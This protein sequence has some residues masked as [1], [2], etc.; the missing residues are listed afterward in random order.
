MPA[1]KEQLIDAFS[2]Q[3]DAASQYAGTDAWEIGEVKAKT[4]LAQIEYR[5]PTDATKP[6]SRFFTDIEEVERLTGPDGKVD[7]AALSERL[8]VQAYGGEYNASVSVYEVTNDITVPSSTISDNP[9][10]G[11]GGA[12]QY[13]FPGDVRTAENGTYVRK[14]D[15]I[16][17][18]NRTPRLSIFDDLKGLDPE[19]ERDKIGDIVERYNDEYID[20][21]EQI[22]TPETN[23]VADD[24][25]E[26]QA[27]SETAR[28]IK[29]DPEAVRNVELPDANA[30]LLDLD[31]KTLSQVEKIQ[32]EALGHGADRPRGAM[33]E[34]DARHADDVLSDPKVKGFSVDPDL[35]TQHYYSKSQNAVVTIDK[36][37]TIS[38]ERGTADRPAGH[39]F[40]NHLQDAAE[41]FPDFHEGKLPARITGGVSGVAEAVADMN[42]TGLWKTLG[43]VAEDGGKFLGKASKILGPVGVGAATYEASVLE[44]KA[45]EFEEY[46]ALSEEAVTQFDLIL[47]GHVGQATVDPTMVGGEALTKT[48][49]ETWAN[50]HNISDEMK[51]E[52][53]PGLLIWL[54]RQAKPFMTPIKT[55]KVT[56]KTC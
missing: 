21:L 27:F 5:D 48:A 43:N 24:M 8:Q 29:G 9:H 41:R 10:F 30:T 39:I 3:G 32:A 13:H 33:S 16:E 22:N 17:G 51:A 19:N 26:R 36:G 18:T 31:S 15:Q 54:G 34:A 37:G 25:I 4:R 2:E 46:G 1:P 50:H 53:A 6:N 45:R 38:L 28:D 49:F 40:R 12:R 20:A 56:A 14:I 7:M 11:E 23:Q 44:A 55:S 35:E 42:K 52:L 47:V